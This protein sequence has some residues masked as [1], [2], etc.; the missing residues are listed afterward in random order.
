MQYKDNFLIYLQA[1]QHFFSLNKINDYLNL[2]SKVLYNFVKQT[3]Y[4]SDLGD[5]REKIETFFKDLGYR[6][7]IEYSQF[8]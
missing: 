4:R 2:P 5:F 1:N 3:K 8:P 7:D 6:E